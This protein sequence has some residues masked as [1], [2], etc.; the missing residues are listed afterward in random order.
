MTPDYKIS[1]KQIKSR[2]FT[3][4]FS[5]L[6]VF[7][8]GVNKDFLQD[9]FRDLMLSGRGVRGS[10]EGGRLKPHVHFHRREMCGFRAWTAN[11]VP[12]FRQMSGDELQSVKNSS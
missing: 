1:L 11:I 3:E 7:I 9:N 8:G 5:N 2:G 6:G 12:L 10:S 4:P